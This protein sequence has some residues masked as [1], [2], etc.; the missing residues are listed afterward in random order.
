MQRSA[1][2]LAEGQAV[3]DEAIA[4][5]QPP[6]DHLLPVLTNDRHRHRVQSDRATAGGRLGLTEV[7]LPAD[8]RHRL[9]D[10][11]PRGVEVDVVPP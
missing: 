4:D 2:G 8:R 5:D 1:V 11:Q 7:N 3:V 10:A 6:L 9:R